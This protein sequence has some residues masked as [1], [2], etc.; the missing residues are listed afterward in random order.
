MAVSNLNHLW[1]LRFYE[2]LQR[3]RKSAVLL[4]INFTISTSCQT[5]N[6]FP[7]EYQIAH[8]EIL[9]YNTAVAKKWLCSQ[10]FLQNT[11]AL[12]LHEKNN[13]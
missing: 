10:K 5:L 2:H 1:P 6:L 8:L 3:E 4:F 13:G 11:T 12:A 9:L 7:N